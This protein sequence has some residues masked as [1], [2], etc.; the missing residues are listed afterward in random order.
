MAH[1]DDVTKKLF[2]DMYGLDAGLS[3]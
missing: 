3:Q 2:E 1:W